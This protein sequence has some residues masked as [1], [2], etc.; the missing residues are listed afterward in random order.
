MESVRKIGKGDL[1]DFI[2]EELAVVNKEILG[3]RSYKI[4]FGR[5]RGYLENRVEIEDPATV[6]LCLA[7]RLDKRVLGYKE[8]SELLNFLRG[9]AIRRDF[10]PISYQLPEREPDFYVVSREEKQ[11][12]S[13]SLF[14]NLMDFF[15]GNKIYS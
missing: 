15:K 12:K 13:K 9:Q 7:E 3:D 8:I 14:R 2:G 10:I 5:L 11:D 4:I 6:N 1:G